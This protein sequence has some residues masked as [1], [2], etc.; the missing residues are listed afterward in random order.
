MNR[1]LPLAIP[2]LL[3]IIVPVA[4]SEIQP[5]KAQDKPIL[6]Y[7]Y[8]TNG[9]QSSGGAYSYYGARFTLNGQATLKSISAYLDISGVWDAPNAITHFRYALYGDKNG[10]VGDLIAQT[11][12]GSGT[13]HD[14]P[15]TN[16]KWRLLPLSSAVNLDQGNYW[17]ISVD[18]NENVDIHDQQTS[19]QN[20]SLVIGHLG[21][22]DFPET[23]DTDTRV[24]PIILAIYA[25]G[26]GEVSIMPSL[27]PTNLP[28]YSRVYLNPTIIDSST[29]KIQIT[30]NLT[31]NSTGIP[32]ADIA[33]SY[34]RSNESES[35]LHQFGSITTDSMGQFSIDW[36]PPS[37]GS[38]VINA[39]YRGNSLFGPV[40]D[41]INILVSEIKGDKQVFSVE[42]NSTV[43]GIVFDP[44]NSELNLSVTGQTN[45]IGFIDAHISKSLVGNISAVQAYIDG[46]QIEYAVTETEDCWILHF[47]Y[48]H[49]THNIV[50]NLSK[51]AASVPEIPTI[52][53]P[54]IMLVL[55]AVATML[56]ALPKS[57]V[58]KF[59][60]W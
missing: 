46:K 22:M 50:F 49:S 7:P 9:E 38:Y 10:S 29:G 11:E 2:I 15:Q 55:V 14:A 47:N 54:L 41:G 20:H 25:S 27:A 24:V 32:F 26:Q 30:G 18:D 13:N 59:Q 8:D 19:T 52:I 39:T 40:F 3:L 12:I 56:I 1:H 5:C 34:R 48:H 44:Q 17:L 28:T 21:S 58:S 51:A 45:T 57:G 43:T 53:I 36:L 16:G 6:G 33:F 35:D 60:T 31:S 23:L 4:L 42:S 37:I